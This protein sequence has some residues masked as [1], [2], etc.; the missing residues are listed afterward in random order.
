MI[1]STVRG[2]LF[3]ALMAIGPTMALAQV[4]PAP[5]P[6]DTPS[7]RVGM[8]LYAD[9]TYTD[10]PEITDS[11][12]NTVNPSQF[13]VGRAYLNIT[14]NVNHIV[15]FRI[16]PDITRPGNDAGAVLNGNLV[17]RIKYAFAQFNLDD[18]MRR[19]SW[20]RLGIQ[21]TPW[22]DF[23][24]NIYRYRFQGT[25]F[26]ERE[27]YMSSSD[28]GASFHYDF[29]SNRAEVHVGVY[30]GENY[31][32][33][34]P[35]DQKAFQ[36]RGSLRPFATDAPLLGGLRLH[37]FY[38][39]D[40]YVRDAERNRFIFS[41]TYEHKYLNAGFDYLSTTDQTSAKPGIPEVDGS[42]FSIW[43]TPKQSPHGFEALLRY[44][45]MKPDTSMDDQRRDRTIVG[46]AYWF[47]H[48]GNVSAALLLDY[49]GQTFDGF[50]PGLPSQKRIA[51]HGLV[52]F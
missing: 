52:S 12:G 6:D 31:N 18:W 46:V 28:A 2:V 16:T 20:V 51:V 41:T 7:I 49:D 42:G 9:Y 48:Q 50:T 29:P 34:D 37:L 36:V 1:R 19:G 8:T 10:N 38:T 17:F 43:A 21:Q 22:V 33:T 44:D 26:S 39:G 40:H 13:N 30:N 5:P 14:G 47:P 15:A 35:N 25:V 3:V 4:T 45:H 11:D 24:E 23:E 32:R 27:G